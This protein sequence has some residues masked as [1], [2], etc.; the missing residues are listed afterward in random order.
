MDTTTGK[1][2]D[3][4]QRE[5]SRKVFESAKGGANAQRQS[6]S[7]RRAGFARRRATPTD[8]QGDTRK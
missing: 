1:E 7:A 8:R 5:E 4:V 6:L 3:T 2:W